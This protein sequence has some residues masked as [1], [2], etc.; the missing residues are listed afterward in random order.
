MVSHYKQAI[1]VKT[2]LVCFVG[3]GGVGKITAMQLAGL[4]CLSQGLFPLSTT[5]MGKRGA[6]MAGEHLHLQ[7]KLTTNDHL[8]PSQ[9]AEQS[10]CKLLRDGQQIEILRRVDVVLIDELGQVDAR[11]LSV[12][13]IILHQ[14]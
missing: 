4:Y 8:A 13:D 3:T 14:I 5:L 7:F 6:A 9:A 11:L 1:K 10:I 2:K 12:I